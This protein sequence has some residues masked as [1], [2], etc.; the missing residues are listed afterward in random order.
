MN[1][2]IDIGKKMKEIDLKAGQFAIE[3]PFADLFKTYAG[4][5]EIVSFLTEMRYYTLSQL[6]L[7]I[8]A[9]PSSQMPAS[10]MLREDVLK[11]VRDGHFHIYSVKTINGGIEILTGIPTGDR[12][13]YGTYP[14]GTVN[15]LVNMQL[16]EYAQRMKDFRVSGEETG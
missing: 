13:Q 11:A 9:P 3:R 4:Y 1:R 10:P 7:F 16:R 14:E 2:S 5:P 12:Q 8:Q 6:D 15:H